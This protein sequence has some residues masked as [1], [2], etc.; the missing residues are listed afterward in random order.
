MLE[1]VRAMYTFHRHI[2]YVYL[3]GAPDQVLKDFVN[4]LLEGSPRVFESEGHHLVLVVP[5]PVV[6]AILSSYGCNLI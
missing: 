5:Q 6:K 2:I 1:V 4:H 3:H